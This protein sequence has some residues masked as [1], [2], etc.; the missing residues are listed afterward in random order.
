MGAGRE[1][2]G[3][4]L[5]EFT[6]PYFTLRDV[7]YPIDVVSAAKAPGDYCFFRGAAMAKAACGP[8]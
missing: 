5:E 1:P 3:L 6:V 4:W 7:G 8:S 2:T